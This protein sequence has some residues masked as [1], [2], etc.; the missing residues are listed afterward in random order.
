MIEAGLLACGVGFEPRQLLKRLSSAKKCVPCKE[1]Y[2][3]ETCDDSACKLCTVC[4][5]NE[6]IVSKCTS[7]NDTI[8]LPRQM[9]RHRPTYTVPKI[10]HYIRKRESGPYLG[11]LNLILFQIVLIILEIGLH[12]MFQ[13]KNKT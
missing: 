11:K 4:A 2:Y 12:C 9:N 1:G 3:S 6:W 5:P 13:L 10:D 8:C 7:T